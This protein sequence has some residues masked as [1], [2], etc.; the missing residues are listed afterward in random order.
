MMYE[1]E[2]ESFYVFYLTLN[3]IINEDEITSNRPF[4]A[5][6]RLICGLLRDEHVATSRG[7]LV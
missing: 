3:L 5:M 2:N 7:H 4:V 6:K 1:H